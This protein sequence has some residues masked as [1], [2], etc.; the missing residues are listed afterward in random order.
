M[1]TNNS[2][3]IT[4][5]TQRRRW[6]KFVRHFRLLISASMHRQIERDKK[7]RRENRVI[8]NDERVTERVQTEEDGENRI[9]WCRIHSPHSSRFGSV[10]L[11]CTVHTTSDFFDGQLSSRFVYKQHI[12]WMIPIGIYLYHYVW[13]GSNT[14]K[15]VNKKS[16]RIA[17]ATLTTCH[18]ETPLSLSVF[19]HLNI[20][21]L[22]LRLVRSVLY[23]VLGSFLFFVRYAVSGDTYPIRDTNLWLSN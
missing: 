2:F 15:K 20:S 23:V 4:I 22:S 12:P 13:K 11:Q 3:I 9:H 8:E 21:T 19:S 14:K 17:E 5:F 1:H 16:R 7:R 10:R 6:W 18:K